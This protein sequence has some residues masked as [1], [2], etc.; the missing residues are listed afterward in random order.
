MTSIP[1]VLIKRLTT[2]ERLSIQRLYSICIPAVFDLEGLSELSLVISQEIQFKH[3]LVDESLDLLNP[4]TVFYI[5]MSHNEVL[6]AISIGPC[7]KEILDC[8]KK[9]WAD[10]TEL[11][12]LYEAPQFQNM[13]IG[14]RLINSA[15]IELD[16]RGVESFCLDSGY[17]HAQRKWT[18]KFGKPTM[19]VN[20][21]WGPGLDHMLWRIKVKDYLK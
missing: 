1:E 2:D 21:Y 3:R 18:R 8:T 7:G 14:T 17:Q 11:G 10:L 20:D 5:A 19:N 9:E 16:K 6:G 13:G 15:I 12:S 4:S